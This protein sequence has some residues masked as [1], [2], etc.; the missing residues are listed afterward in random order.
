M[1]NKWRLLEEAEDKKWKI[2]WE[3]LEQEL[4]ALKEQNM[5]KEEEPDRNP[6]QEDMYFRGNF[7]VGREIC[8]KCKF[9]YFYIVF[10]DI[11][12]CVYS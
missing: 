7:G 4:A 11:Y 5:R 6:K 1:A 9:F 3:I 10:S 12:K 8:T 2:M